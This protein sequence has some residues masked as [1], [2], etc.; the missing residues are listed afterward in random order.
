VAPRLHLSSKI[1][2]VKLVAEL[3]RLAREAS[4][5]KCM[6]SG[7]PKAPEIECIWA[8]GRGRAWFC[9]P[10]FKAWSEEDTGEGLPKDIVKQRKVRDGEVG[11]SYGEQTKSATEDVWYH[12]SPRKFERFE[13]QNKHT[14]GRDAA[15][16]PIFLTKD[17]KFA[18]LYAQ[19]PE[20]LVYTVEASPKKIFDQQKLLADPDK[21]TKYWPPEEEDMSE[22]GRELLGALEDG[23]IFEEEEDRPDHV[24]ASIYRG[25][26]DIMETSEMREWLSSK[27]Y[28]AF[29]VTG[30]GPRNLAVMD[31]ERLKIVDSRPRDAEA[32][33]DHRSFKQFI[34]EVYEGGETQIPNPDKDSPKKTVSVGWVLQKY[35][36]FD[37]PYKHLQ[38]EFEKWK[39]R[40]KSA[41]LVRAALTRLAKASGSKTGDGSSGVG[42]F[43]PLPKNLAKKFPSLGE[44]DD[45]PSHVT[46]LY[47]GD[48]PSREKQKT[49]VDVLR[50]L[51]RRWWP[52]C[53]ATLDGL[54]YFDH[55]DKDRR[56]PHVHVEFDRDMAGLRHR[57]KQEL[58]EAGI[59]V[60][61]S[62]PEY[63]PH[64]TWAYLP[65]MDSEWDGP[66]PKGTWTFDTVEVW[67]LPEVH[68][69]KLG[70]T[71]MDRI[72]REWLR[73]RVA[74]ILRDP[75]DPTGTKVGS[76]VVMSAHAKNI[77]LMKWLSELTRKLGVAQ[78]TYVVG[79]A[80]RNF[81]LK[82]P[83][84]DVDIVIDTVKAHHD[85]AWLAQQ[86]AA[87]VP[88]PTNVTTNQYGVAILTV[89]GDWVIDG[90]SLRDEVIEI[91]DARKESY[92]GDGGKGYK[93]HMVEP[94]TI[95]EDVYRREFT[96]NSLLWRLM[97]LA[98]GPE[99][100]E[101]ID[102][103]G[104][105]LRDLHEGN[106]RC[107]RE[108]DVVFSDDPTRMLRAIKFTGKYGF[109]IPP[110]VVS[111]IRRNARKLKQMPWEAV[112]VLLV[113]EVLNQ[114][115][116]QRSL[117]QMRELG[118]LDAVS[119]MLR[120]QKPFATYMANQL[121]TNR[122]VQLLL[123]LMELGVPASTPISFLDRAGQD[124]LRQITVAMPEDVAARFVD[125]LIKPPV[126]NVRVI[127]QLKLAGPDRAKI[128]PLARRL[129]LESPALAT[130]GQR[131]TDEVLKRWH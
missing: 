125:H 25:N 71:A 83:I 96:F 100:A 126:D 20:G 18:E 77:A 86:I 10:H 101:I 37:A 70:P 44:D 9:E 79:G 1:A 36:P 19:G 51:L 8:D 130:D 72:S 106:L 124:R 99:R 13:K 119:E 4:R 107:P 108:P 47:I 89:K 33:D 53:T 105:G 67:G 122:K 48:F 38:Q 2:N 118:L 3:W 128:I 121:R 30:D 95:E 115:T 110:D 112:A 66:V 42:L 34:D 129:I 102:L 116:A 5:T 76:R 49:L 109:K 58:H 69:I 74:A 11:K 120:E 22:L 55:H 61:D 63:R 111:S 39:A 65:G 131:L 50:K 114:P 16:A 24:W 85:S 87:A 78:H 15:A 103:T 104:C 117:V 17:E 94:A 93:P 7:C 84:K 27:G 56:V 6:K 43:I 73:R 80:V 28:D 23:K 98:H 88:V 82:A 60:E 40:S 81:I 91:A 62:F 54:E 68:K 45:S 12:G 46:F 32:R 90:E 26:Y 123:D 97:D 59:T 14:F 92:G 75:L 31:P 41:A 127:D 113:G 21:P 29:Y 64:V 35:R 52:N 57:L